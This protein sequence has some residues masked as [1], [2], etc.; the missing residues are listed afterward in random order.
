M[1]AWSYQ[2][3]KAI[4]HAMQRL[5]RQPLGTLLSALVVGI[6]LALPAGGFVLVDN[7][8]SLARGVT[9]SPEISLYLSLDATEADVADI[10][11]RLRAQDALA[12]VQFVPRDAA[13]KQLADNGL[14]DVLD[15][16]ERNPL[17]HAFIVT[18]RQEDPALFERLHTTFAAWPKVDH[19][20]LDAAW[21]QR[22]HTLLSLVE[23]GVSLLAVLLGAA[24]VII[25]FN[26][27]RLQI[28]TQRAEIDVTRLLGAT[29][30][31]IRRPFYWLGCL[32]GLLGGLVAWSV[33]T[34]SIALMRPSVEALAEAYGAVF[35]LNGPTPPQVLA[36]LVVAIALGWLGTA[37][38]VRRHLRESQ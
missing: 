34:L 12:G 21:V 13:L 29:D 8:A 22:L 6:A 32:Q 24:L 33:V 9:G 11:S 20:Q 2:H 31:F 23:L 28:L 18:P 14:A 38:S 25:T 5:L 26:T 10:E 4:A 1:R 19:V 30:A 3:R 17:P 15:G 27:I 35:S 7:A 36:L 37:L 16:L